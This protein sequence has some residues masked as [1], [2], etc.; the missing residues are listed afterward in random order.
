M[1]RYLSAEVS[2]KDGSMLAECAQYF[3]L[4]LPT[5][6]GDGGSYLTYGDGEMWHKQAAYLWE[7]PW[8]RLPYPAVCMTLGLVDAVLQVCWHQFVKDYEKTHPE[9][10]RQE[11][12]SWEAMQEECKKS[13]RYYFF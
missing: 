10:Q 5:D 7:H 4:P 8:E 6:M 3:D 1:G 13:L 12:G 9:F 11:E 2:I